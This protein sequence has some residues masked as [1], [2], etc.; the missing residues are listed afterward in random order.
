MKKIIFIEPKAPGLHIFSKVHI[1][2][3]GTVILATLAKKHGWQAEV[4]YEE[5]TPLSLKSLPAADLVGI[6]TITSTATRAFELADEYRR[7]GTE[8]VLGGPHVT[9]LP[10]E[11]L[12]HA[13]YAVRGEGE[14]SIIKLLDV[15]AGKASPEG[16]PGL[17]FHSPSGNIHNPVSEKPVCV[18]K[19]PTPDLSLVK[20][21]RFGRK[22]NVIPIETSRGC[23]FNC[24]FCS[25]NRIFGRRMRF[26]EIDDII[27]NLRDQ[28]PKNRGV[29]FV[30]DNF[31][32]NPVHT[33]QLLRAM[34]KADLNIIWSA[35]VRTDCTRDPE[36][37]ELMR[38]AGCKA[39]YIGIETI[40]DGTLERIK[41]HQTANQVSE[42]VDRFHAHKIKVHGMFILG[43]DEDDLKTV[44]TTVKFAK[45]IGL[46]TVQF[47]I[48]TP[49]PGTPVFYGMKA[50][51]RL[52]TTEWHYYDAHHVV[53]EP[54]QVMP[55]DLQKM[56]IRAH[57]KFYSLSQQFR[58]LFRMRITELLV[59]FYANHIN[60]RWKRVNR[61][62]MAWLKGLQ[63]V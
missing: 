10:D 7:S 20:Q 54:K 38:K 47:L 44:K 42:S 37:L 4:Y 52:I 16:V 18:N 62:F 33:K 58:Q 21:G 22:I 11:A 36:L 25:V 6:S 56:Q 9:F 50:A 40:N 32:A 19:I 31:T 28:V 51:N 43:F 17:S 13:D 34:I 24:E 26:R 30:D 57:Q 53:Y 5:I 59:S 14:E 39:V 27:D 35:Q 3:L 45:K 55:I 29:F 46:N 8:V 41:K 1:P 12:E 23:P 2:R 60:T 61:K 49:L 15:L 48:L 63:K